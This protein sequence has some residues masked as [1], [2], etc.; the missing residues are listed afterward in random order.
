MQ[1]G[2]PTSRYIKDCNRLA[3][4]I[5]GAEDQAID[6][7]R[8]MITLQRSLVRHQLAADMAQQL[9]RLA[10]NPSTTRPEHVDGGIA[11]ARRPVL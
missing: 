2:R 4:M 7:T 5:Y 10:A 8:T 1:G 3:D 6:L 11:T 9:L